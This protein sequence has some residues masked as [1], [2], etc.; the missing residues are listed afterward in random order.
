MCDSCEDLTFKAWKKTIA[1]V[2][3]T[4]IATEHSPGVYLVSEDVLDH[5]M[6]LVGWEPAPPPEPAAE[7]G[8]PPL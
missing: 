2:E 6:G 7:D 4:I 8:Q 1:G 3:T 5:L